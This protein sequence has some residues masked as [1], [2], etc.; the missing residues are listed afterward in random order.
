MML[1]LMLASILASM[2]AKGDFDGL[3]LLALMLPK[4]HHQGLI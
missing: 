1:A 4:D 2:L 3:T